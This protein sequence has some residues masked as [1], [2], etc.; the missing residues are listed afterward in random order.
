MG[1]SLRHPSLPHCVPSLSLSLSLSLSRYSPPGEPA[2][3]PVATPGRARWTTAD[4][5]LMVQILIEEKANGRQADLGWKP[6]VWTTVAA[7]LAG[8]K[9]APKMPKGCQDHWCLLVS[10]SGNVRTLLKLSGFGWDDKRHVVTTT[11]D[12][13]ANLLQ[14]RSFP[15]CDEI[16]ALVEGRQATGE[17][18]LHIANVLDIEDD[19]ASAPP[20]SQRQRSP[21]LTIATIIWPIYYSLYCLP[22]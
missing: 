9:G 11:P 13:W 18:A 21:S 19:A 20:S 12:V 2:P 8:R 16:A 3:A 17:H 5:S 14:T 1:V 7:A 22:S 15:L 6:G 4:D 10:D